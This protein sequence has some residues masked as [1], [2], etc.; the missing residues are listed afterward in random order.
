MKQPNILFI[1]SDQ[2]SPYAGGYAGETQIDT[3]NL[4]RLAADGTYF[5]NCYCNSPLCVPSRA[6]ML[7]GRLPT[8]TGVW[9]NLQCLRTDEPTF[10]SCLS[11]A[12]Y[13]TVLSGRM[14]FIGYDQRHGFETRLVGDVAP[15]FPRKGRQ[16]A[17]YGV[18]K[19][20]PDQSRVCI[21]HSGA[22]QSA[23]TCFDREVTDETCRFL[24]ERQD[25]CPLFMTVGFANPHCPF[26]APKAL[27]DKYMQRLPEHPHTLTEQEYQS[28]HP[29]L[30]KFLDLRN[31]ADI[32][33]E[34]LRRVRAAYY[35]NIEYMDGLIGEICACALEELGPDTILIY[36]SDHGEGAGR[37]G[38]F[39]KS[40]FYEA[41]A[42][43]PLMFYAPHLFPGRGRV[44]ELTSL[45]DLAPTFLELAGAPGLPDL[46]G[47]SLVPVL[48]GSRLSPDRSIVSQLI[49]IKGDHPSAMIRQGPYKLI[50]YC[51]YSDMQ[52]FDL[53]K[54]PDEEHDLGCDP[55]FA[56]IRDA[57]CREL[58][59]T[60]DPDLAEKTLKK[61]IQNAGLFKRWV[62]TV[63]PTCYDE[64]WCPAENNY[65]IPE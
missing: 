58:S 27:Y 6:S 28:L 22:G 32:T 39:W 57:L 55:A 54:D 12:G 44:E 30:Q 33:A 52:L 20:T 64:W 21:E 51:G 45:M 29:A 65:L 49:D 41:S 13:Q 43:V 16:A 25:D 7:A 3:P 2:H 8:Q 36:A 60:W 34:E 9:N 35:A 47:T 1:L 5:S 62:E 59:R 42:R 17:L 53:E 11:I 61:G 37:H 4:D 38:L 63:N 23:M 46:D 40:N 50:R 15:T 48:N 18:L 31:A 26:V 56:D 14:H 24:R 19:G 10:V